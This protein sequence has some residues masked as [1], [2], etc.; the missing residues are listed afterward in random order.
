MEFYWLIILAIGLSVDSFAASV[1]CGLIL[2]EITFKKALKIAFFLAFFQALMPIIGWKIGRELEPLIR[3][4]DHW[5]AFV[6]LALI[7]LKMVYESFKTEKP[8]EKM[9]P[10]DLK[11]L[12]WL[13]IATSI[14]ALIAG[15][16]FS[17]TD[18]NLF[19]TALVIGFTTGLFSML[20]IL[21][22]KKT[23]IRFGKNMEILGGIILIGIGVKILLDHLMS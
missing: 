12:V 23:G 8:D 14:D 15:I 13:S 18:L 10:L 11:V 19:L 9:N 17:V 2:S 4:F 7:G 16:G 22:G 20:G 21:F 6:L 5:V 3:N 1:S